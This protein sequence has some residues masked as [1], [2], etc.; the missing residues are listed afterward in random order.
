[1]KTTFRFIIAATAAIAVFSSCQKE[2]VGETVSNTTDGVRVI[3][4]QFDNSTKA[5]LSGNTP[6]FTNN[7]KIRVS[8]T[9]KSEECTV[10]VDGSGNA[11]FTTTLSG[12]L[13]AIYPEAAADYTGS[14]PISSQAFKVLATQ[15]GK[16]EDAII[17]K[18]TIASNSATFTGV[19]ALFEIT[20]P[21]GAT[22]FTITS[23]NKIGTDGQRSGT[24]TS[25][26][27]DGADDAK[28]C[29]ITVEVP[30][31]GT[32]Y[33][34]LVP[35][36]NLTDLSFEYTTDDTH[37][38][39]KGIPMKDITEGGNTDAT[40]A[41]TKYTIDDKN[42]HPYVTIGG[43]KWAT[44]NI[45]ATDSDP[46][47]TYFMWGETNG[48]KPSASSFSFPTS[49]YYTADNNSWTQS[50]GFD[51][52]NCPWT[53][54]TF[55]SSSNK[56]V[57]TKYTN[58]NDYA[59][60]GTADNKT[61]LDLA[62][63]AAYANWGGAWRMP[64]GGTD[65][66]SDFTALAKAA[67]EGYTSSTLSY[68]ETIITGDAPSN[69]GVYYYNVSGTVGVYFVDNSSNKL[70]F[71]AAGG[72]NG[73]SLNGAGS[74]GRYWSSSLYTSLPNYAYY[75]FIGSSYVGPQYYDLR[76]YGRSVRP[77]SD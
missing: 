12:E 47:G 54:G 40:A 4:V 1:M 66:N 74:I 73:T 8:N 72:G 21:S 69:Q 65:A 24:A 77:V 32:A 60:S 9:E 17:A 30:T 23:L 57:F 29:V 48:I 71:P 34:S 43:K 19:T 63:D 39:M 59:K 64:T 49:K 7:D 41:N 53:N 62:D 61:K 36:V 45:G 14:G 18:A 27:T 35:G 13:T 10:S 37:G 2:L 33:V 28:K 20:P 5:S 11:T 3:S 6:T 50:S 42:W 51:W 76:Y 15:T 75:L 25:I 31:G 38:A 55:N 58:S 46:Y 56:N 68:T 67:D 26:N 52:A 44:E 70:F 16:V 22:S